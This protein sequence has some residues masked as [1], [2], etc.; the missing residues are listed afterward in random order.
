MELSFSWIPKMTV[1]T[2]K[3]LVKMKIVPH[4][5]KQAT[6]TLFKAIAIS[7]RDQSAIRTQFHRNKRWK[8][9]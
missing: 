1:V 9:S 4:K 8:S 6:E 5:V 3:A 2:P 7:K